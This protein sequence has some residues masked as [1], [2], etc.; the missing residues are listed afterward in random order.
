M[1]YL[2]SGH[3]KSRSRDANTKP[4]CEYVDSRSEYNVSVTKWSICFDLKVGKHTK[5]EKVWREAPLPMNAIA[6]RG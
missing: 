5:V 4:R 2:H 3:W 6:M 1:H